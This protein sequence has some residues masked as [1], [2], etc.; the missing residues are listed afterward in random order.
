MTTT[1][2]GLSMDV[3]STPAFAQRLIRLENEATLKHDYCSFHARRF[4][5]VLNLCK[6]LKSGSSCSV[7]DV[8]RSQLSSEL[9]HHYRRVVTLGFP[10]NN[11]AHEK[12]D[13][14]AK[15]EPAAHVIFDLND[16]DREAIP[17]SERFDL[18]VF[19]ETIEHLYSAP[20][21]VLHALGKLLK[22]DGFLVCQTPNA[23]ALERRYHLLLGRNPFERI[24]SNRLNLGHFREYTRDELIDLGRVAGLGIVR[25]R[26]L[27]YFPHAG[28]FQI[29]RSALREV[30]PPLRS[31][32]T[33]IYDKGGRNL[34][35]GEK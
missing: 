32:Q 15:A 13:P 35:S 18:I 33:I 28:P 14:A 20:E 21:I 2:L 17:I 9:A 6:E 25:H 24:R 1:R 10:L 3:D 11:F 30:F 26:Y 19:A 27:D 16:C 23:A 5:Y 7:L 29:I 8:G 31:G 4:Q 12:V 22:Q 34:S